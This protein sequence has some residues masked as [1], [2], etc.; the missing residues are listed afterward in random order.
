MKMKLTDKQK[1]QLKMI[2]ASFPTYENFVGHVQLTPFMLDNMKLMFKLI[3]E[4]SDYI[5]SKVEPSEYN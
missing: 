1:A 3:L 2:E 5:T 4:N